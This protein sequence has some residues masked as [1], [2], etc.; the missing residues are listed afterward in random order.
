MKITAKK[1]AVLPAESAART[2]SQLSGPERTL[3]SDQAHEDLNNDDT[4][5]KKKKQSRK[6]NPKTALDYLPL[7]SSF[8]VIFFS[9]SLT[10]VL[11][12]IAIYLYKSATNSAK[13]FYSLLFRKIDITE[14]DYEAIASTRDIMKG[15]EVKALYERYCFVNNLT[16]K[17]L[18]DGAN[19]Q[20]VQIRISYE[21]TASK[22]SAERIVTQELSSKLY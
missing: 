11:D 18:S 3:N 4:A 20:T 6:I 9:P 7:A 17:K 19:F 2:A 21:V 15:L 1:A 14:N 5:K 16:E 12:L 22:W 13:S 10:A 8:K